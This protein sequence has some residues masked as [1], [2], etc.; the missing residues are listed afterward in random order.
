MQDFSKTIGGR[1]YKFEKYIG[2]DIG[3]KM[4]QNGFVGQGTKQWCVF[5]FSPVYIHSTT[6]PQLPFIPS[7]YEKYFSRNLARK[8]PSVQNC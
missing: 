5:S 2:Y 6:Y 1:T 3:F 7:L 4:N 8:V